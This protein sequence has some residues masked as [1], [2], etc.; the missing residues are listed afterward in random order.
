MA[1]FDPNEMIARFKE[2]A[3]SVKRRSLPPVSGEERQAF[4]N[5]A[6]SDFQD[7]AI[8]GDAVASI[9]DGVL[10]LRVNLAGDSKK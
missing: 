1:A 3:A 4:L 10:V 7:F 8:I 6:Q 2:R 5:Q 9:E